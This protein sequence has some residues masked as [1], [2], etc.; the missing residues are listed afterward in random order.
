MYPAGVEVCGMR[1]GRQVDRAGQGKGVKYK[2]GQGR[3]G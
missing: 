2:A 3:R 1:S